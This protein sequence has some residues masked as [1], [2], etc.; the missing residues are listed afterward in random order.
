MK[1]TRLGKHTLD[2]LKKNRQLHKRLKDR[3]WVKRFKSLSSS[4]LFSSGRDNRL[5]HHS[6]NIRF[7]NV[8]NP[9]DIFKKKQENIKSVSDRDSLLNDILSNV[10]GMSSIFNLPLVIGMVG[11]GITGL[12]GVNNLLN[13]LLI[14]TQTDIERQTPVDE[15]NDLFNIG[16]LIDKVKLVS[17]IFDEGLNVLNKLYNWFKDLYSNAISNV[18]VLGLIIPSLMVVPKMIYDK[19]HSA[20]N[21]LLES[22]LFGIKST[23]MN[24]IDNIKS[25]ASTVAD[26]VKDAWNVVSNTVSGVVG[27]AITGT[28]S[29]INSVGNVIS[30]GIDAGKR[31]LG[32]SNEGSSNGGVSNSVISSTQY[33]NT[34]IW[35][36]VTKSVNSSFTG[37]DAIMVKAYTDAGVPRNLWTLLK[38]QIAVE[39]GFNMFAKS[40]VG[41]RGLGQIMPNT[42]PELYKGNMQNYHDLSNPNITDKN[43]LYNIAY[44]SL[45]GQGVFMFKIIPKHL[46]SHY[47]NATNLPEFLR[48]GQ[49][50]GNIFS[51]YNMGAGGVSKSMKTADSNRQRVGSA[52][53]S[54]RENYEYWTKIY[55]TSVNTN[56]NPNA[57]VIYK[58]SRVAGGTPFAND[59]LFG[60]GLI[61]AYGRLSE[62]TKLNNIINKNETR[63]NNKRN[64]DNSILNTVV[65]N[66]TVNNTLSN[67]IDVGM[68]MVKD[69]ISTVTNTFT[70]KVSEVIRNR[71]N[72]TNNIKTLASTQTENNIINTFNTNTTR[73]QQYHNT[74]NHHQAGKRNNRNNITDIINTITNTQDDLYYSPY[75]N[76]D[77]SKLRQRVNQN[78]GATV[79]MYDYNNINIYDLAF[80][81]L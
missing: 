78:H 70:N 37:F 47:R 18:P 64:T 11:A 29:V 4:S 48:S 26:G 59:D 21:H 75:I 46:K 57:K 10:S 40:P 14:Q 22:D 31:F 34:S 63:V 62:L 20:Y 55:R 28:S 54:V 42:A 72:T 27:S 56:I 80:L 60:G 5:I 43:R 38:A 76:N 71:T 41:A 45:Y 7:N 67:V 12:I 66:D 79:D 81:D 61:G 6:N 8:N 35:N 24:I 49:H 69:T 3:K 32:I 74:T 65:M 68:D 15:T 2:R 25:G 51:A 33:P 16:Q 77:M 36:D 30:S 50:I 23:I 44:S 39:S 13:T 73:Y 17:G 19:L 1:L 52:S 9:L 58:G 53:K